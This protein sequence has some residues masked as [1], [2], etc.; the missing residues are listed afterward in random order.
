MIVSQVAQTLLAIAHQLLALAT[1]SRG[2]KE[3]GVMLKEFDRIYKR[4]SNR[5]QSDYHRAWAAEMAA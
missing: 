3:F 4:A 2:S 1:E 5:D